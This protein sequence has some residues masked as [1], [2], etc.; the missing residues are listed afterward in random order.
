MSKSYWKRLTQAHILE[1]HVN[2]FYIRYI[3]Y[4]L[5]IDF[6]ISKRAGVLKV[7]LL[8]IRSFYMISEQIKFFMY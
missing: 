8:R 5:T 7:E 3:D 4:S 1:L 6:V 2:R